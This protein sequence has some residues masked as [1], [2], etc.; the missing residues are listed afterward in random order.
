MLVFVGNLLAQLCQRQVIAFGEQLADPVADGV[1]QRRS[2][3]PSSRFRIGRAGFPL[4]AEE[5]ADGSRAHPKQGCHF[6][7]R[8]V[9]VFVGRDQSAA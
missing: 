3:A 4:P 1:A 5:V 2:F 9:L 8:V 7:L 6:A